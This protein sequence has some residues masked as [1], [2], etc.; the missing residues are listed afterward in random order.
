MEKVTVKPTWAL[1]WGL[2][3]RMAL[4]TLGIY[5]IIFGIMFTIF[6]VTLMSLLSGGWLM[7]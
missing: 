6:G 5:A 2:F 4:I 3:W 7:P 1:A